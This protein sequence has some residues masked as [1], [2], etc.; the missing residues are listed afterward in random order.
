MVTYSFLFR[1]ITMVAVTK[2]YTDVLEA[3]PAQMHKKYHA[4]K[5]FETCFGDVLVSCSNNHN[6]Y[7]TKM[8]TDLLE[9][10]FSDA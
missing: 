6:G 5:T 2:R 3:K 8:F 1:I 4:L 7:C 10:N 9:K